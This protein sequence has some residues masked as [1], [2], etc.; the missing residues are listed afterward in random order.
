VR[1]GGV[2]PGQNIL[3]AFGDVEAGSCPFAWWDAP[4]LEFSR[5]FEKCGG[6]KE[7]LGLVV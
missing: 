1:F 6:R 3:E 5:S 2:S 7:S 4:P